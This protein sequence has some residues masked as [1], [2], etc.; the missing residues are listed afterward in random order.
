MRRRLI[1]LVL[2]LGLSAVAPA[3]HALLSPGAS[4]QGTWACG[5]VDVVA[6][7]CVD[8]PLDLVDV[9]ELQLL[10]S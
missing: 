5:G 1:V 9:P 6:G 10:G 3:A 4:S 7:V 8:S 2:S